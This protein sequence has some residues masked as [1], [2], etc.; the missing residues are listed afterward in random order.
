MTLSRIAVL[1]LALPA[2]LEAAPQFVTA[3]EALEI[4]RE[5]LDPAVAAETCP[6]GAGEEEIVVCGRRGTSPYRYTGPVQRKPGAPETLP[7]EM[8]RAPTSVG[9]CISRCYQPVMVDVIGAG[10]AIAKGIGKLLDPDR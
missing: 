2:P 5:A 9:G 4:H 8:A 6:D 10:I 7:G 1:A 3:E